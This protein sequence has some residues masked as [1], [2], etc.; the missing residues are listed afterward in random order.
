ME[1]N[2][3]HDFG[4]ASPVGVIFDWFRALRVNHVHV[5]LLPDLYRM[6]K[7]CTGT[8]FLCN[9]EEFHLYIR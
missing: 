9:R 3:N 7:E 1:S 8:S 5:P 4:T 6:C 2:R